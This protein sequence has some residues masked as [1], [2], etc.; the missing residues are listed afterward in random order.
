MKQGLRR[1]DV[2]CLKG[3]SIPMAIYTDDRS[4]GLYAA[5]EAVERT[6]R[7]AGD[8]MPVGLRVS[9]GRRQSGS[10]AP[11]WLNEVRQPVCSLLPIPLSTPLFVFTPSPFTP[12]APVRLGL[13]SVARRGD[14][15]RRPDHRTPARRQRRAATSGR[16]L[17]R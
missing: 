10:G 4:N 15:H 7:W 16:R 13:Q 14:V 12:G 8:A 17:E 2:V 1:I 5:Q 11:T 3:S 9:D 6:R